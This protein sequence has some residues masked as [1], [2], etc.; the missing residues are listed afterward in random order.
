MSI[1]FPLVPILPVTLE[2][3]TLFI[4]YC[5][6]QNVSYNMVATYVYTVNYVQKMAGFP[7][8]G[9]NFVAKKMLQG[10]RKLTAR[11]DTK[12]PITPSILKALIQSLDHFGFSS[13]IKTLLKAMYLLAFHAFLRVGEII[14]SDPKVQNNLAFH[15]VKFLFANSSDPCAFELNFEKFK[16]HT[17]VSCHKLLVKENQQQLAICPVKAFWE[18][19]KVRGQMDGLFFAFLMGRPF[20]AG[21]SLKKSNCH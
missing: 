17:G 16:H 1:Y 13:F 21:F 18:Y 7:D 6:Q 5:L 8:I 10:L 15:A 19:C 2:H 14:Q 4:A 12:L 9:N 11:A 3:I 20:H